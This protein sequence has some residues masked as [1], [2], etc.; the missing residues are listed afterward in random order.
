MTKKAFV[1]IGIIAAITTVSVT[2]P[3]LLF[4]RGLPVGWAIALLVGFV[5]VALLGYL[6]GCHGKNV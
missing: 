3:G 4:V 5:L 6:Y 1:K 2:L